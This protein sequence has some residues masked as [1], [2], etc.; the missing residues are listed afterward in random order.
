MDRVDDLAR[1]AT[2]IGVSLERADLER[3]VPV[4]ASLYADL[5]RL[6]ALPGTDMG[7]AFVS[8]LPGAVDDERGADK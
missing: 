4:L 5:D 1:M 6:L 3:L 2:L 7:P 8:R